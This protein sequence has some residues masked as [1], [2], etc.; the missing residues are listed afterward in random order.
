MIHYAPIIE[1]IDALLAEDTEASVTYAALEARLTLERVCYDRLK[2]AHEYISHA[3]LKRWQP[4][5]VVKQLIQDVDKHAADTMTLMMSKSPAVPGV[6]PP[7]EDYVE[8]GTQVGFDA[9]RVGELWN[10]LSNLALH[11]KLPKNKDDHISDYG[12]RAKIRAKVEEARAEFERLAKGTMGFS[13]IGEQ[14]SFDCPVCDAKNKRR[15]ALLRDQQRIYCINPTCEASFIVH[16]EGDD[17]SFQGETCDFACQG[18]GHMK[19]LPWRFFRD[20]LKFG[21]TAIFDCHQCNHR[22]YVEW[23]LTQV[24]PAAE[25]PKK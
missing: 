16:K 14:V 10:A 19:H 4:S 12:D 7:D 9:K 11:V 24:T 5:A 3:E 1:R 17:I 15:A 6:Q 8:I 23:R 25:A 2:H 22:N 13:G 20:K 18:C 21:D